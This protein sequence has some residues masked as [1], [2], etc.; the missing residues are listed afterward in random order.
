M[1]EAASSFAFPLLILWTLLPIRKVRQAH[2]I[3]VKEEF[4]RHF[5]L[6]EWEIE[7]GRA[8]RLCIVTHD[9]GGNLVSVASADA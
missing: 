1:A 6:D 3:V 5:G 2:T 7:A 9:E 4:A 8:N